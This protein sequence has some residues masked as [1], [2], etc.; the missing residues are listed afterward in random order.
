LHSDDPSYTS[1]M[2]LNYTPTYRPRYTS[3]VPVH[4]N[5]SRK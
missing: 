2:Y 1:C 4:V 5:W 3:L